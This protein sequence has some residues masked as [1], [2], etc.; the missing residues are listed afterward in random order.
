MNLYELIGRQK[1]E[2]DTMHGE[3]NNLLGL[4]L[5]VQQGR[6]DPATIVIDLATR[7]W[8]V[9]TPADAAAESGPVAKIGGIE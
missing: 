6:V 9:A 3:Y 1:V 8:R 5:A 2:L 7:S 4:L